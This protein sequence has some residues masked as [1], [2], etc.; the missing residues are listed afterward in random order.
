MAIVGHNSGGRQVTSLSSE[1]RKKIKD[2][3]I[4]INDSMTRVASE[5]DLQKEILKEI[6]DTIG[7]DKK[8]VRKMAKTYFNANY[9]AERQAA[10]DFREFYETVVL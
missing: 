1:D 8:V 2:A 4:Q 7:V 9:Q 5:R 3:I 6:E 10:E